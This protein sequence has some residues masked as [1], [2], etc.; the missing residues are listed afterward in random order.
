MEN[1]DGDKNGGYAWRKYVGNLE[2]RP[3]DSSDKD[4]FRFR[5][6]S[7]DMNY[8]R[9]RLV[10]TTGVERRSCSV[11]SSPSD[12]PPAAAAVAIVYQ[13]AL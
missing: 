10:W 3:Q 11:T 4:F 5:S 13:L 1:V 8:F 2:H 9:W 12:K 6:V 7:R